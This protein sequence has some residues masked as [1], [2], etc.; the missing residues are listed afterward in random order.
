MQ[1][2]ELDGRTR[3]GRGLDR[4]ANAGH[5]VATSQIKLLV[6]R[7]GLLVATL[8]TGCGPGA[9]DSPWTRTAEQLTPQACDV[10]VT[11]HQHFRFT[12]A[13]VKTEVCRPVGKGL[14]VLVSTDENSGATVDLEQQIAADRAAFHNWHSSIEPGFRAQLEKDPTT[15]RDAYIWFYVDGR[16]EPT[17]DWL[18]AEPADALASLNTMETRMRNAAQGL[19]VRLGDT[20]DV[21]LEGTVTPPEQYGIPVV[22]VRAGLQ[23]LSVIGLWPEVWRIDG[24]P[25]EH[26]NCSDD[27]YTTTGENIIDSV[28]GYD[29]TG[30]S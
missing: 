27:Y 9:E 22:R 20:P 30:R 18:V 5:G 12:D 3:S 6:A 14:P 24:V 8:A 19:A 17:K 25:T 7:F 11:H 2:A 29:G 28:F 1:C 23:A 21:E 26:T 4:V 10:M 16:D 15:P 13:R